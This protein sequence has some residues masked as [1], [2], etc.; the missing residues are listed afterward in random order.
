MV[1]YATKYAAKLEQKQ[2][3][4]NFSDVGRFW[5]VIGERSVM[6]ATITIPQENAQNGLFLAFRDEMRQLLTLFRTQVRRMNIPS[7]FTLG[8][9]LKTD[10]IKRK[11]TALMCR[12]GLK[13][14]AAG[15][16]IIQ[17]PTDDADLEVI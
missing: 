15:V 16:A 11:V 2:V 7:T 4:S 1:S 9:Y 6:A 14:W 10:A 17:L 8:Y 12:W 5:G 3:P 13:M